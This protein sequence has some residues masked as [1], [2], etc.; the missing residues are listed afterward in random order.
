MT[1]EEEEE[2]EEMDCAGMCMYF[3]DTSEY[4]GRCQCI[5]CGNDIMF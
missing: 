5:L 2:E 4:G 3:A 1:D